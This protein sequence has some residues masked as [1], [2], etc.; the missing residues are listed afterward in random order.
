MI[1]FYN[2]Q[3]NVNISEETKKTMVLAIEKTAEAENLNIPFEVNVIIVD[4]EKIHSI[5]KKYRNVDRETD[6]LSFPMINFYRGYDSK[7]LTPDDYNPENGNLILGDIVISAEK[8]FYQA[9]LYEHSFE[10]EITYL[11]V[12]SMLHLLGYDHE[13]ECDKKEM[14]EKEEN[15]MQLVNLTM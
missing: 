9:K 4:N 10:R 7:K 5:N 1:E 15:I 13:K 14:R 3:N 8:A 2:N 6:V 12:H 11:S